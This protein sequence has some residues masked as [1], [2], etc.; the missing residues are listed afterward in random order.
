MRWWLAKAPEISRGVRTQ[1]G[2]KP[3]YGRFMNIAA[4]DEVK[5]EADQRREDVPPHS[6][7]LT[8]TKQSRVIATDAGADA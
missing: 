6:W 3:V 5:Q 2:R 7:H 8:V 4:D 1:A